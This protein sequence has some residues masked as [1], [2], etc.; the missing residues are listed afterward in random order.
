ME[1]LNYHHL[2]Y[3]W[4]VVREGGVAPAAE[5]LRLSHPTVSAQI[6]ALEDALG[7]K[8]FEKR[9]RRLV[10]TEM[11]AV[12]HGYA[13]EIFT[14]G[15]ELQDT[16]RGRPTG[17]P[18]RLTVGIA[19]VVPKLVAKRLIDPARALGQRL[20][21]LC[22]EGDTDALV[23]LLAAHELDVVLAD[24]PLRP[25]GAVRAFNHLLGECGVSILARADLAGRYRDGF[26]R[27][28]DGAPMLLPTHATAVRRGLETLFE[29]LG[30]RP[31]VEAEFDDSALLKVFGQDG[32]GVFPAPTAI[33]S[34]VCRQYDVEVVGRL[35]EVKERFYALTVERRIRHPA[36]VALCA[37]AR[38]DVFPEA[39]VP[40][41]RAVVNTGP[42]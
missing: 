10:L 42:T 41:P 28:L 32:V 18:L 40:R 7:E 38:S 26:P 1:W 15:R 5:R 37:A 16:V 24:A 21:L 30:V 12:V 31:V 33:E 34:E 35:P 3:F 13:D 20:S 2:L 36:V 14:L 39:S 27:S 17:R 29:S 11:G 6:H 19:D 22:R 9:G 8:L 25:G 4:T 23:A